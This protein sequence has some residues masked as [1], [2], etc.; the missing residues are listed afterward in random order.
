MN[1]RERLPGLAHD[2]TGAG[3]L[4]VAVHGMTENRRFWD[5]VPLAE[6]FRTVRVDLRGHGESPR[7]APYDPATLAA[8]VHEV[9]TSLGA[10]QRPL[11]VGHSF[12]GVVASAYAS[13]FP[14]RGVVCVDQTLRVRPLPAEVAH[15][16]RGGGFAEFLTSGFDRMYGEL[17]SAVAADLGRRRR[18]RQ[19]VMLEM[20]AP[21]LD[22]GAEELTAFMGGLMPR[23][24]PTPF[25]SLHGLPVKDDY[26]TWLNARIPGAL[27]ETAPARTHY[28]HLAE[29]TWFVRRL[30]DFDGTLER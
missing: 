26:A 20:W 14:V 13:L 16:V 18:I 28:P 8:D 25:L 19:D 24:Q 3:P 9:V 11:V 30:A 12:G 5:R 17:D 4:L 2:V 7:V 27:V 10:E 29:P 23:R 1:A 6:H 15:A 21:L 22:L